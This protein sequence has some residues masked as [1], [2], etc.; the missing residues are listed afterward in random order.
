VELV[1]DAASP[2]ETSLLREVVLALF[3]WLGR[4]GV[5]AGGNLAVRSANGRLDLAPTTTPGPPA[6][7]TGDLVCRRA[8]FPGTPGTAPS[9][10]GP[11]TGALPPSEWVS[12]SAAAPYVWTQ[13]A[14]TTVTGPTSSDPGTV[15]NI[16]AGSARV[17][18]G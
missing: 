9:G 16:S 3:P 6:A 4:V 1:S 8:F 18:I 10:G 14:T 12:F 15:I 5:G 7:R 13:I 17:T 11:V 2:P